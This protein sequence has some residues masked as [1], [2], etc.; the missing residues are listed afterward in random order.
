MHDT[1]SLR[2]TLEKGEA[3]RGTFKRVVSCCRLAAHAS[4]RL[5]VHIRS[6]QNALGPTN[7]VE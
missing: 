5:D 4:I 2:D 7:V 3:L 1:L 6:D